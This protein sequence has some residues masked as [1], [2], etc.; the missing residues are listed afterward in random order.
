MERQ[1][2]AY[3]VKQLKDFKAGK[4][5]NDPAGMMA[6]VAKGMSD[7]EITAVSEYVSGF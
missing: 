4:R 5:V 2:K 6:I 7:K 1:Q 3:L